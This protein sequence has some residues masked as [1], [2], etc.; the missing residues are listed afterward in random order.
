MYI[1]LVINFNLACLATVLFVGI[2][3]MSYKYSNSLSEARRGCVLQALLGALEEST[4][5]KS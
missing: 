2:I 4:V 3:A 1:T 5:S